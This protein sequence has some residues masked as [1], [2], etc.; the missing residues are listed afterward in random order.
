MRKNGKMR[1]QTT[2][3]SWNSKESGLL[4]GGIDGKVRRELMRRRDLIS[5]LSD[6]IAEMTPGVGGKLAD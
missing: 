1:P 3:R 4:Y 2:D 5:C 6:V